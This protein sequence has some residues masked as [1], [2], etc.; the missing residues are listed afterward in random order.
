MAKA[1][2]Q[3]QKDLIGGIKSYFT[4]I[5][6]GLNDQMLEVAFEAGEKGAEKIRET[7]DTTPSAFVPGKGNRNWTFHMRSRVDHKITQTGNQ[8]RI[9]MGWFNIKN[10]EKYFIL[11]DSGAVNIPAMGA[12]IKA[13]SEARRVLQDKGIL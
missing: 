3:G 9:Q 12:L 8:I 10:D 11:Q 5:E 13:E 7:I 4:E 6:Q 2:I 1:G